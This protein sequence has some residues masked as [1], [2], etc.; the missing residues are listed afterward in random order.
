MPEENRVGHSDLDAALESDGANPEEEALEETPEDEGA[1][2]GEESPTA[3]GEGEEE[4]ES[5]E[6]DFFED[7][8][9]PEQEV[10]EEPEDN[11][12]RSQLGR[13]VKAMEDTVY[14]LRGLI[15]QFV[16]GQ[17][18]QG[19]RQA[20]PEEED[21]DDGYE[22]EDSGGRDEVVRKSDLPKLFQQWEEAKTSGQRKYEQ[23]YI[24]SREKWASELKL[25]PK[26]HDMVKQV[27]DEH[28]NVRYSNDPVRD[29][30][31]NYLKAYSYILSGQL[32]KQRNPL[33][34]N[35][36]EEQPPPGG[37]SGS[38]SDFRAGEELQ[39]DDAAAEFIKKTGMKEDSVKKALT[40][41][42][43]TYLMRGK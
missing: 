37:A 9:E 2:E 11:R 43:P 18:N 20:P 36:T 27:M 30:K 32:K 40:G 13:R 23:G 29:S 1:E 4:G 21:F 7:E 8:E 19:R 17:Q 31:E 6:Y 22:E 33:A 14:E 5:E 34:K 24:Q 25:N 10:P 39:L 12:E 41:N 16:R 42:M 28:F 35:E 38:N 3:T 15:E 26:Q